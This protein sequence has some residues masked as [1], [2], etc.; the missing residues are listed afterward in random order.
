MLELAALAEAGKG[1]RTCMKTGGWVAGEGEVV[2][3][4]CS[5]IDIVPVA[6]V[7]FV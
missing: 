5:N 7:S 4:F 2:Y 3:L 6:G 1:E